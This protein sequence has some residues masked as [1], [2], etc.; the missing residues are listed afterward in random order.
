MQEPRYPLP[1][2]VNEFHLVQQHRNEIESSPLTARSGQKVPDYAQGVKK[3]NRI[4]YH[5]HKVRGSLTR[6]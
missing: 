1:K 4:R 2:V 3:V 6:T 5:T